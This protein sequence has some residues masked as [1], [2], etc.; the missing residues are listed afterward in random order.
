MSSY[1]VTCDFCGTRNRVP[2]EKEG[3][4][5]RCGNCHKELPPMYYRSHQLTERTFDSFVDGYGKLVLVEFWAPWCPHC[6]SFAPTVGKI[7]EM[8]A[9]EAA[10]VQVN[11]EENPALSHRFKVSGI[12]V[13]L[14]LRRGNE[15][16]R[17]AGAQSSEAISA[18]FRRHR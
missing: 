9:G 17:L 10:V 16:D 1:D 7:A 18:W 13:L 14:L 8:L 3:K 4:Q 5:G 11:T 6:E 2:A 15:I 12:P